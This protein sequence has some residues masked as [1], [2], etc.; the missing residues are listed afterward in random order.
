MTE[1][2]T[3]QAWDNH[4]ILTE[5]HAY[6]RAYLHEGMHLNVTDGF[7]VLEPS[8][9]IDISTIAACFT[10][11]GA[12]PLSHLANEMR[13]REVTQAIL[14]GNFAGSAL[15][16][17]IHGQEDLTTT[18]WRNFK[19]HILEFCTCTNFDAKRFKQDAFCQHQNLQAVVK[20]LFKTFPREK[21]LLEPSFICESLGLQGRVDLMTSDLQLLI[22][23]KSGRNFNIEHRMT[24]PKT[25]S[26][27]QENH[28]IQ[29]LL[30]YAVLQQ[31]FQQSHLHTDIRLLYSKYPPEEGLLSVTYSKELLSKAIRL[32]NEIVGTLFQIARN[33]FAAIAPK[34]P[35]PIP[36]LTSLE[37]AYWYRMMTFITQERLTPKQTEEDG[38][39]Y[40]GLQL[41][42]VTPNHDGRFDSITLEIPDNGDYAMPDFRTGDSVWLYAYSERE[43]PNKEQAILYKGVL[44]DLQACQLTVHL[45]DGQQTADIITCIPTKE[46]NDRTVFALEHANRSSAAAC[47]QSL[48]TWLNGPEE[49][50]ELLLSQRNPLLDTSVALSRAYHPDYDDIVLR[51]KQALDYFLIIGPPGTGK[52]SMALQFLVREFLATTDSSASVLL[53]A[54]TNRAVDEI[55]AMLCEHDIP[56]LRIGNEYACDVRFRPYLI[57][58]LIDNNPQLEAIRQQIAGSRI[59]VGTTSTMLSRSSL[60]SMKHFSLAIIDEASQILEPGI[61]GLLTQVDKFILIGDHKQLP[62]V[63]QQDENTSA[64][65]E[66]IL[67]DICLDNCR[68]SLFERL[69]RWERKQKRKDFIG[70][71]HTQ[72]RMHPDIAAFPNQLFYAEE[73]LK[74]VPLPHQQ[75]ETTTPRMIF[76]PSAANFQVHQSDK[77]NAEEAKIVAQQ[78]LQIYHEY[79]HQFNPDKTVGVIVPYRSQ[80]AMI[81]KEIN[82]RIGTDNKQSKH[83]LQQISIDT[84]ERYQGSQRDIIIYSFTVQNPDQLE[85]LTANCF[86]E[87]GVIIDRKLNV[88]L[89]RARKRLIL[90]GNPDILG[91]NPIF[92]KLIDFCT[93]NLAV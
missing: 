56:F 70:T 86:E 8:I 89:T 7:I 57:S 53:S 91:R 14:L 62:A 6:L 63:V 75:E 3:Y 49:K 73:Q 72:G 58:H 80:I 90:T 45:N 61:I 18:I 66:P 52:T 41:L 30:Y 44:T 39:Q 38:E 55:C 16:D 76:I 25:N 36:S 78:L 32:R 51:A 20:E 13:P 46:C 85:F 82:L 47:S 88:A 50:R 68:H 21:A 64:V 35:I 40:T 34:L 65:D 43:E 17:I 28:Y 1:S 59:L 9:L 23:Q 92:R 77:V 5:E 4:S 48:Y 27:H 87:N 33:G 74:A 79:G 67:Q 22:E 26:R 69:L 15:D 19:E 31:N 54:Y 93:K 24:D 12:N 81:R 2:I 29:L 11:N 84:V 83:P 37:Q 10:E 42:E 60:F 71:L